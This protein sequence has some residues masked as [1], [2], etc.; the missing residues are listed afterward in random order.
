MLALSCRRAD[1]RTSSASKTF[2]AKGVYSIRFAVGEVTASRVRLILKL[3]PR[4]G[5]AII[6]TTSKGK[7]HT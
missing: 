1:G 4:V 7:H 3:L 2:F 6:R 5:S